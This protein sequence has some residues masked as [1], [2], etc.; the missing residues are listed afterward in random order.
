MED[1]QLY[2]GDNVTDILKV[3]DLLKTAARPTQGSNPQ[4]GLRLRVSCTTV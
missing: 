2:F 1:K 4:H 3:P